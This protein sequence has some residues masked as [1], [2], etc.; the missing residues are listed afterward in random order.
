MKTARSSDGAA[1]AYWSSGSGPPLLLVHGSICDHTV[2]RPLL[3]ALERRFT[4]HAMN[5][6]GREG[7]A[8][9][10]DGDLEREFADVAAVLGAI[11]EP[12]HVIGHSFGGLCALGAALHT[13]R[14]RSLILYEPPPP[15]PGVRSLEQATR[16]L[17]DAGREEEAL[18]GFVRDGPGSAD[19]L[20]KLRA[21][22]FWEMSLAALLTLPEEMAAMAGY[23]FE[24]ERFRV[25]EAPVL[26][27]LGSESPPYLRIV[28]DAM[29][30]LLP[31]ARLVEMAGEGHFTNLFAPQRFLAEVDD[32]L[33]EVDDSLA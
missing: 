25:I 9:L 30:R 21:S 31:N 16:S 6:R 28:S 5:R 17:L 20:E 14:I 2:W 8:P 12:S 10:R 27:L 1:L 7:S 11:G 18:S 3:P 33:A 15:D 13:D 26:L 24:A 23:D 4:V 19:V 29:A 32:F 22:A